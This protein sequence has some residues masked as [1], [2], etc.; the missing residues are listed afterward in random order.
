MKVSASILSNSIKPE[1]LIKK[2][3]N[4]KADYI[5]LDVMDGKFVDNKSYTL[6]DLKRFNDISTKKFDVHLMVKNP[7]KYMYDIAM[8]NVEYVTFHFE[9]VKDIDAL[10]K[11]VKNYGLKVGLSI[12]P[13]TDISLLYPYLKILDLILI[14]SVYPGKSG[15]AFISSTLDKIKL[16]KS[17]INNRNLNT[18]ISVDGGVN[19]ENALELKMYGIDMVVSASFIQTDEMNSRINYLK[20]L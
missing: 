2:F 20:E 10:I 5:H 15:Q 18:I 11:T 17:E 6:S 16:L 7:E 19:S 1:E 9:A 8:L 12:N 13:D 3:N 4:T 14:M